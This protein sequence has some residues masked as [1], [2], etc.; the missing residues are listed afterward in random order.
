MANLQLVKQALR[1][2][3]SG[4]SI[5]AYLP[6][7]LAKEV[8]SFIREI[9]IMRK[10]IPT[11]KMSSREWRKPKKSDA[12]SAYYI[13][14]G[15]TAT[16]TGF[17]ASTV[18]WV[19]KKLMAF[20]MIDEE[21][22]EDAQPDVIRQV[23]MDFAEAIAE[24]EELG[25]LQGDSTHAHSAP[26]PDAATDANW[27]VRDPRLAFDGIFP[28]AGSAEAAT[29]VAAGGGIFDENMINEAIYNLGKFGRNKSKIFGLVPSDQ[30]AFIRQ[31]DTLKA[32][33]LTGL[34]LSSMITGLQAAGETPTGIVTSL[35][36]VTLHEAPL[37]PAGK[38]V[39][40]HKQAAEIGDRRMIK[41]EN[42]RVIEAD[43]RK[44]VT[45]ER[46]ALGYNRKESMVLIDDLNSTV[47]WQNA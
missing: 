27:Y 15:V 43:Q 25:F 28:V 39:V 42:E 41:M 7:P 6:A 23:L 10:L 47:N 32:A 14:D 16:L 19:A 30:A 12:M 45:S 22:I 31:N 4:Q 18:K 8:I 44:F 1:V 38:I 11:F 46:I 21:S 20:V 29:P 2:S 40:M 3:Q 26:T 36:G 9:N 5:A 33:N 34:A 37:A 35:Y 13:P 24:A 17:S